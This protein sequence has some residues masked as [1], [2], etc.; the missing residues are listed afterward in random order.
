MLNQ[1]VLPML[2]HWFN[3]L[4]PA[5]GTLV[6]LQI[7]EF[8]WPRLHWVSAGILS[9]PLEKGGHSLLYICS[10]VH[11]LHL[12]ALHSLLY[13][14]SRPFWGMFVHSSLHR[15][16]GSDKTGSSFISTPVG[17]PPRPLGG[18]ILLPG[19][20]EHLEASFHD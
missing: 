8:F 16:Q 2:C 17:S 7:L 9:L 5:L 15:L 13:S 3:T 10:Q 18:A 20:P 14:A 11:G 4:S 12:Q 1:L 19:P 6:S